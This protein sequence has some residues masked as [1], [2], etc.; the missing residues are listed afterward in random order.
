M[1]FDEKY[2]TLR[3]RLVQVPVFVLIVTIYSLNE[4]IFNA[5]YVWSTSIAWPQFAGDYFSES[6]TLSSILNLMLIPLIIVP[7][8]CK[9]YLFTLGL[10]SK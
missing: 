9:L 2:S 8:A 5:T 7:S 10:F 4:A 1:F 3:I 6:H